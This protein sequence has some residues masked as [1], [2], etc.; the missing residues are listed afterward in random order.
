MT[1]VEFNEINQTEN[2]LGVSASFETF[3]FIKRPIMTTIK[4][5]IVRC[6][7]FSCLW[8]NSAA[9]Y[10]MG[11]DQKATQKIDLCLQKLLNIALVSV[12][13]WKTLY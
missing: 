12:D 2:P 8:K 6:G 11:R 7:L 13:I 10:R 4:L 1:K 9:K 5:L 3:V